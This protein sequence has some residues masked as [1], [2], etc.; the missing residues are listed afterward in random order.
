MRFVLP[1]LF[2][3]VLIEF[4][5]TEKNK[6]E[7]L[8]ESYESNS[9]KQSGAG[10]ALDQWGMVRSYP[11]QNISS[12]SFSETYHNFKSGL[13]LREAPLK[14][15]WTPI[16]P[17]N[18]GGR[19]L[20][21]AFHPEKENILYAGSASGGL[22]VSH[23]MGKG[24]KAW[25]YVQ[26]GFPV[27]GVASILIN[28]KNP[29]I[30]YIGTGE[31][32]NDRNSK[33]ATYTRVTR[34][35]YGIGILKSK[36]GGST[37]EKCLDWSLDQLTGVQDLKFSPSNPDVIWAATTEGL[38]KTE[39][40][41]DTWELKH[42]VRMAVD[43]EISN[44]DPNVIYVSHGSLQDA[45]FSGIYRS[46]NGGI[47]FQLLHNGIPTGYTGKAKIA[48]SLDDPFTL[49]AS[50]A[51]ERKSIG[52]F[53]T[54]DGGESWKMSNDR[55]IAKWQ[56]WYSHDIAVKP[57]S[58][59]EIVT[60]GI[61]VHTSANRGE[62]L[63]S[64]SSWEAGALGKIPVGGPEGIADVYVHADIH[65][66]YFNPHNSGETYYATDG[67]IFASTDPSISSFEGRN[68][69]FQTS[70]FYANFSSS[71]QDPNFA[72]G[73]LQD[74]STVIYEG[75]DAW[76]KRI[77][78]D[79]MSTAI[80]HLD[81]NIV[82]ASR[83]NLIILKSIDRGVTY[84]NIRPFDVINEETS[85]NAPFELSPT[86]P[87]IIY[88]GAQ[89]LYISENAG[90]SWSSSDF[91]N[92][93]N[94]ILSIGAS[95]V[96]PTTLYLSTAPVSSDKPGL[97]KTV[98]GG[99]SFERIIELPDRI[100]TDIVLHP[101]TDEIVYAVLSGFG[102]AHVYKSEDYG[103]TWSPKGEGTIPDVPANTLEIDPFEPNHIYVG[104]DIGVYF[105]KDG[106]DTWEDYNEGLP[107]AI[108]AMDLNI[109]MSNKKLRVATH[110]NGV[111]EG[112]LVSQQTVTAVNEL[113]LYKVVKKFS[114]FPNPVRS[115]TS[116][117]WEL[118]QPA[119]LNFELYDEI[120]RLI[121]RKHNQND[122]G[123]VSFQMQN[124]P[125]GKYFLK[126][127]GKLKDSPKYFRTSRLI[128]KK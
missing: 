106:G 9:E 105:S 76:I 127:N 45:S 51:D 68:G 86:D 44:L 74:N 42:S 28:P 47:S 79:G 22:W 95:H 93:G 7:Y 72:I 78:G 75:D 29:N 62:R 110:G 102:T 10:L 90:R 83:E 69:G 101:T 12:N 108:L 15:N 41:G 120:G 81:D 38:Y 16:G 64:P 98:D 96:D 63:A 92:G 113:E 118:K 6:D 33:P 37:W 85:F 112:D 124:L 13:A 61:E 111:F 58:I 115:E 87:N 52:I 8:S 19:S 53:Y 14:T 126:M 35:T 40:A 116:I 32:Y 97:F 91:V 54:Q 121:V 5:C 50:V 100:V 128:L 109:S 4:S 46:E 55:N 122:L 26:T 117:I 80:N 66:V 123:Q 39:D 3:F 24:E 125:N 70:Q 89:K 57:G 56:G 34:G 65:A 31:V 11:Y 18:V 48:M 99:A 1:I 104:N 67:G 20:C 25:N 43:V 82:Y 77:G 119:D 23:T 103:I 94:P 49:Y 107:D 36:D 17:N 27:L 84:S 30:M 59:D 60:V 88:A 114:I 71:H 73:G 2:L 21:L